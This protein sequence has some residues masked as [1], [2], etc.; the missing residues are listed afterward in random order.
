MAKNLNKR[1]GDAYNTEIRLTVTW[2]CVQVYMYVFVRN[3]T[4]ESTYRGIFLKQ[5]LWSTW[6][7]VNHSTCRYDGLWPVNSTLISI[8][9]SHVVSFLLSSSSSLSLL[10]WKIFYLYLPVNL[11]KNVT[12]TI[13]RVKQNPY[14]ICSY[15]RNAITCTYLIDTLIIFCF[16]VSFVFSVALKIVSLASKAHT[17]TYS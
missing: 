6:M 2:N 7:T 8:W 16:R 11:K 14:I 3:G 9:Y 1:T 10:I 17:H 4:N 13:Y 15:F 12:L 5:I